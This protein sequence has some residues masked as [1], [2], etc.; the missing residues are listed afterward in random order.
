MALNR[1]PLTPADVTAFEEAGRRQREAAAKTPVYLGQRV[2]LPRDAAEYI[3]QLEARIS[4]LERKVA[5]LQG[6]PHLKTIEHRAE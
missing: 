3:L 5:A 6:P 4:A 2:G 1:K